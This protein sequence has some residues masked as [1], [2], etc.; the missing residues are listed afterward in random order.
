M[1]EWFVKSNEA[2]AKSPANARWPELLLVGCFWSSE[3]LSYDAGTMHVK[4]ISVF[5]SDFDALR[6]SFASCDVKIQF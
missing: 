4:T 2:I 1:V 5:C 3:P 6:F